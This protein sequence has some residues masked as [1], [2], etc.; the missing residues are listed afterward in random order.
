MGKAMIE[1]RRVRVKIPVVVDKNGRWCAWADSSAGQNTA[2]DEVMEAAEELGF[3]SL[4]HIRFVYA[5]VPV[6]DPDNGDILI[7]EVDTV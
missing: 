3:H 7:G 5:L 2:N 4:R 6:P 1:D